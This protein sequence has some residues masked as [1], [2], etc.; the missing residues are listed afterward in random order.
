MDSLVYAANVRLGGGGM[1]N[2]LV[3]I[4]RGLLERG[5]LKQVIVSSFK[6]TAIPAH[7]ITAQG[8]WGRVQKRLAFYEPTGWGDY[9]TNRLFDLWASRVMQPADGFEGWTGFC[10]TC[11]RVAHARGM[12]TFL[13][14]GS[15]HPR[16]QLELINAE[17]TRWGL[18]RLRP[19]PLVGQVERELQL[20]DHIFVQSRFSA[21]TLIE[22]GIAAEKLVRTPLGVDVRRFVP[23]TERAAHPFRVLF[24]GQVML[25]KGIQYLLQA[26]QQLGWRDAELWLVG[27]TMA[28]ARPVLREYGNLPG[29]RVL[30]YVPDQVAAYQASDVFVLPSV[31]DGFALVV[32]EAMACALPV[33][34]SDHTGAADL[35]DDGETGFVV[36]YHQ[37]EQYARALDALRANTE[38]AKEMGRAGHATAQRQTWDAYRAQLTQA[39]RQLWH[40]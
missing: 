18:T 21:R 27:K 4:M 20:A 26:W 5:W 13:G 19:T 28:D 12:K 8:F 29:V 17:R 2:S 35:V 10:E 25:R 1:G 14:H 39:H 22:H 33:I 3:E 30:G 6:P 9:F 23:A 36:P 15:A 32:A 11:L 24:V 31:E 40:A 34:V 16:A 7:L 38:R 37:A